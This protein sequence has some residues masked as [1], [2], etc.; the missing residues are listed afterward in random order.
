MTKVILWTGFVCF[1]AA[2][3]LGFVFHQDD[4]ASALASTALF[5]EVVGFYVWIE[6][7]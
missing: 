5:L 4:L 3:W 6:E 7:N 1:L 2:I